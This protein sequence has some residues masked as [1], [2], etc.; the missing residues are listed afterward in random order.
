[1]VVG[2]GAGTIA[3]PIVGTIS[4]AV[5]GGI[6]GAAAAIATSIIIGAAIEESGQRPVVVEAV[7]DLYRSW[8]DTP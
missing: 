5:V 7:A 2:G 4:G 3:L 8:T 1:M 6:V